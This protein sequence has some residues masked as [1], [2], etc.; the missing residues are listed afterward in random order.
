MVDE[1]LSEREQ[2][3]QLRR[4]LRENWI[5]LVAG[6]VLTLAGYYGYRWWEARQAG[7]AAVAGE[8][9]TAMLQAIADGRREDGLKIAAEV[10][11]EY[12]DTPYADQATLVLVRL[13]VEAGDFASAE[14][15]LVRVADGSKDPDLRTV[16]RLRLARVQMAQGRYDVALATLD[17]VAA[18]PIDARVLDLKGDVLL[19][20]GDQAGALDQWRKAEAAAA[21]DPGSAAQLDAELLRLKIG[22]LGAAQAVQ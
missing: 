16:A 1:Y 7:R 12:A 5:W 8:R 4:W 15:K 14:A 20:K 6:V 11:G 22:E 3:D 10:T 13:D 21:A 17:A 9:F 19:A 18:P 2:A